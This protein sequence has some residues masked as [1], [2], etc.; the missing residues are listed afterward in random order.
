MPI[1][2]NIADPCVFGYGVSCGM[3]VRLNDDCTLEIIQGTVI[4]SSGT[5]IHVPSKKFRYYKK[6]EHVDATL[7]KTYEEYLGTHDRPTINFF[8][9]A[10]DTADPATIESIKEQHPTDTPQNF[11]PDKIITLFVKEDQDAA[12]E[13]EPV[14]Y[15]VLVSRNVLAN[16]FG[17]KNNTPH[18]AFGLFGRD[19]EAKQIDIITIDTYL[20]P[21]LNLSYSLVRRFGYKRL[22]IINNAQGL[23]ETNLQNPFIPLNSFSD[24]FFEYKAIIDEHVPRFEKQL[25]KLHTHFGGL[26]SHKGGAYLERFRK[27]LVAK[28]QRFYAMG[29]HLYYIQYF[30]D[31]LADLSKA[32]NE[33]CKKLDGFFISCPCHRLESIDRERGRIKPASILLLG[34]VF[35]GSST[36]QPLVFREIVQPALTE[37]RIREVRCLHWRL[38]MMIW[39]FD[40]PFLKLDHVLI[41]YGASTGIEEK[42]DSTNYWEQLDKREDNERGEDNWL[43]IKLTPT[44]APPVCLGTQAIPYY[45]P[46]DSNSIYSV[47]QFWDYFQTKMRRADH[48]LSYNAHEGDPDRSS[49]DPGNDS[50]SKRK[51]VIMP[52]AFILNEYPFLKVEG[53]IG[54]IITITGT[55]FFFK[56]FPLNEYIS[57]YNVC[58]DV[59]AIGLPGGNI[60]PMLQSLNGLEHRPTM[61]QAQTLVLLY[62]ANDNEQVELQECTKDEKPE[63]VMN[64]VVADFIL[65][66]RFSCC[67]VAGLTV[68]TLGDQLF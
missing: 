12:D 33:L 48:H 50:Y 1:M 34:P 66:Y 56:T 64:T 42:L 29:E 5:I 54:K 11:L 62:V 22:A 8:E 28:V 36:Y 67:P 18:G 35:G 65:P 44:K 55:S 60:Q 20:R 61:E 10:D 46:L 43:P 13:H 31:W 30:Y 14:L 45:Y 57:K 59:I 19:T 9:L 41:K 2:K 40:L 49:T 3:Q 52:L 63:V 58:L 15:F 39:S 16:V 68:L 4:L 23:K 24:L 6:D 51:E 47:H 27:I 32:Y 17:I 53:H 7:R 38:M 37:D 25:A 21:E 26:L